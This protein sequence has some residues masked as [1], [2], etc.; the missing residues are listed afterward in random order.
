MTNEQQQSYGTGSRQTT[1]NQ[2]KTKTQAPK[3]IS[4]HRGVLKWLR[5]IAGVLRDIIHLIGEVVQHLFDLLTFTFSVAV[6]IGVNPVAP[7]ICAIILFLIVVAIALNQWWQIGIWFSKIA[8]I[9]VSLGITTGLLFGIGI[10]IFQ[11]TPKLRK[12]SRGINRAYA[13]LEID[14]EYESETD[15]NPAKLEQNWFSEN[16]RKSKVWSAISYC[17][18]TGLVV[19]YVFAAQKGAILAIIQACVS[20]ILPEKTLD[21]ASN[22]ISL[23]GAVSRQV[24]YDEP[25]ESEVNL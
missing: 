1:T 6:K 4:W 23:M 9:P 11:L 3:K 7:I 14:P 13:R 20:L 21:L 10:N 2:Q 19:V 12:L 5:K 22:T 17:V 8:G 16:H 18:E 15:D 24:A 25:P